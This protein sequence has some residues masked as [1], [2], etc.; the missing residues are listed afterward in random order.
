M[1]KIKLLA[2]LL[3]VILA[4]AVVFGGCQTETTEPSASETV[5]ETAS[6]DPVVEETEAAAS[7]SEDVDTEEVFTLSK[8][9][10]GEEATSASE[11]SLTDDEKAQIKAGGYKAA[12]VM[13]Y[14]GNDWST[15]QVQALTDT[16]TDLGI[17]IVAVTDA[18][19][20]PE[21]QISDIETVLAKDP[22]IIISLPTDAV[23]TAPAYQK[24]IDAGV[25][26][27]FMDNCPAGMSAGTDYVSVVSA[28]SWGNGI[29]AADVMAEQI[30]GEGKIGVLYYDADFF[31]TNQRVEAFEQQIAEQYPD[32][33]IAERAGF[34]DA[35]N[36]NEVASAM[37][38]KTPDLDGIFAVW[39]VPAEGVV[40]AART[41][42]RDDLVVTTIDLGVNAA[43]EIAANGIIKGLGAQRPYDQGVTEA[44]LA[45]Y[46]LLGKEAPAF[47]VLPPLKVT[48]DNVLE[49]FEEVYHTPAPE[50][51]QKAYDQAE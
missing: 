11:I 19:F 3:V 21:K 30:G 51:V 20:K 5:A 31:V 32:I 17:E 49:A 26:L 42:G 37:L 33:E 41:A 6:E 8:G 24:A 9:P 18:N 16:F 13:H 14:A 46:G 48:R 4:T 47:V 38:T 15:A 27:V 1:K 44:L 29:A 2:L 23:S 22:D 50:E 12:L 28:D 10:N 39:D 40:A 34:D 25:V 45:C 35:N 43:R 7:E 36:A